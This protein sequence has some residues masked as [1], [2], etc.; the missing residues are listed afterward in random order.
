MASLLT[1]RTAD[2]G[3]NTLAGSLWGCGTL[4][5][6]FAGSCA[7]PTPW[8]RAQRWKHRPTSHRSLAAEI[9]RQPAV[10]A[11]VDPRTVHA[12]Q[13]AVLRSHVAH[14]LTG[15]W[16]RTGRTSADRHSLANQ[17]PVVVDTA[18]GHRVV[19]AGHHRAVAALIQARPLLARVRSEAAHPIALTPLVYIDAEQDGSQP[20]VD[21][22]A[23][24]VRR[25]HIVCLSA[26]A[27][28]LEVLAALGLTP[29]ELEFRRRI[30]TIPA[31]KELT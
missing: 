17:Y 9:L 4:E 12:S 3:M 10:L 1:R 22:L 21:D 6:V 15:E 24:R 18:E 25:G 16:E 30:A 5:A 31:A 28:G 14:Y 26:I 7:A 29:S 8:P 19:V 11:E 23:D 20:C 2:A 27:E 13:P